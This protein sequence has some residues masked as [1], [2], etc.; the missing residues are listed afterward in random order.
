MLTQMGIVDSK[1]SSKLATSK[2]VN[3]PDMEQSHE[4]I[5]NMQNDLREWCHEK[6]RLFVQGMELKMNH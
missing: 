4:F 3:F 6:Y 2:K 1:H 5:L